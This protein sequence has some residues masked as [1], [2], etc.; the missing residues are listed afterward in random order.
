MSIT[1]HWDIYIYILKFP[2]EPSAGPGAFG[3]SG[4]RKHRKYRALAPW[5]LERAA[6]ARSVP[7]RRSNG[8]LEPPLGAPR[9]LEGA[10][11]AST[12]CPQGARRGCSSLCS[13]LEWV[14]RAPTWYPQSARRGCSSRP[15]GA[16]SGCSSL[17]SVPH[18]RSERHFEPLLGA[19]GGPRAT[20]CVT[21]RSIRRSRMLLE[22]SVLGYT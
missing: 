6:R 20:S 8:L 19:A 15:Q 17:C 12:R 5:A 11:R 1:R 21:G 2:C 3:V 7:Q 10:A 14:A 22:E 13:V 18:V 9:A 4:L 16:P